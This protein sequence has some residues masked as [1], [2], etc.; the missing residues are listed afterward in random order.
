MVR[1]L[2]RVIGIGVET[3]DI[4]VNEVLARQLRDRRA[5]ARYASLTGAPDESGRRRRENGLA[6]AGNARVRCGMIQLAWRFLM[7]QKDSALAQVPRAD[8]G[9]AQRH[10]QNDDRRVGAQAACRAVGRLILQPARAAAVKD[11]RHADLTARSAASRPLLDGREHD[12]I[13][14]R[15]GNAR[16]Q[17]SP[18]PSIAALVS[19]SKYVILL[20]VVGR[21]FRSPF[22]LRK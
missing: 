12:G 22:A 5:V 4:L 2:A 11:G 8:A 1:L 14:A 19:T 10:A 13:L 18:R 7:F 6:R 9:S 15:N 17:S 21:I 20:I 16:S 3:A